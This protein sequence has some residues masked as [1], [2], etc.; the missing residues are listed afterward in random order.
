M[1]CVRR[2]KSTF[3]V[4]ID[5]T[6]NSIS[7]LQLAVFNQKLKVINSSYLYC[8]DKIFADGYLNTKIASHN[9]SLL[10]A[11]FKCKNVILAVP[12]TITVSK[13]FLVSNKLNARDHEEFAKIEI[14][15]LMSCGLHDIYFDF[16]LL[17]KT[18]NIT[19]MDELLVVAVRRDYIQQRVSLFTKLGLKVLA[20][21]VESQALLRVFEYIRVIAQLNITKAVAWLYIGTN[22]NKLFVFYAGKVIFLHTDYICGKNF[23]LDS[24]GF[25]LMVDSYVQKFYADNNL[26]DIESMFVYGLDE[27]V[28]LL[29]KRFCFPVTTINPFLSMSFVDESVQLQVQENTHRL[30]TALG[31]AIHS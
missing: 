27:V 28:E 29:R 31:L 6:Y 15:K 14:L 7:A 8:G 9:L 13:V 24:R 22:A 26:I 21:D 1:L 30:I 23:V 20:I 18:E 17:S 5:I 4:G 3:P 2:F 11:K 19:N 12:D 10:L 16:K 25:V